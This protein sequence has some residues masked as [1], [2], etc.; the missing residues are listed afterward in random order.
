MP[1]VA[2]G[3]EVPYIITYLEMTARPEGVVPALPPGMRLERALKPQVWYFLALYDAVGRPYEWQDRFDQ[4]RDDPTALKA[5][6]T[7]PSVHLWTALGD[8]APQGFFQLDFTKSGQC[9][10]AYFGLVQGAI[11]S[12]LGGRLLRSALALG[13]S[14]DG[15]RRMTVNTC[16][17]DHPRALQLYQGAGFHPIRTEERRRILRY[18]R[19]TASHPE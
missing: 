12:G 19:D 15:V 3:S 10:L 2:A 4:E 1:V 11:G 13:W 18:D 14:G 7:D 9:D 17:L 6:A 5:Y 16:T 8:G